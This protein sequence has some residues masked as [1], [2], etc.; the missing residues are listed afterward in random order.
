[1]SFLLRCL[2]FLLPTVVAATVTLAADAD[3]GKRLAM[4]HCVPCHVAVPSQPNEVAQ[5]PPF[6]AIARKLR[7]NPEILAF[8]M[9]DPHPKMNLSLNRSE[10]DDIAAYINTLAK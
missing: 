3:N 6:E 1:M 2:C 8:W 4:M 9:L 7:P 5:A 10:A